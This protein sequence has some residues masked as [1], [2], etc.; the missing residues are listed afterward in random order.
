MAVKSE[1]LWLHRGWL[2][3]LYFPASHLLYCNNPDRNSLKSAFHPSSPGLTNSGTEVNQ[4]TRN[5][6]RKIITHCFV[7]LS[8]S[9]YRE[10]N[11]FFKYIC[12]TIS[13]KRFFFYCCSCSRVVKCPKCC[14]RH[15]GVCVFTPNCEE[16]CKNSGLPFDQD[17]N[18][19]CWREKSD[20][21]LQDLSTVLT[22]CNCFIVKQIIWLFLQYSLLQFKCTFN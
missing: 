7:K 18:L 3:Q 15:V 4:Q 8:Y 2:L 12:H 11:V 10:I 13:W 5:I 19:F 16:S 22:S 20:F 6:Y 17:N 9:S 14:N 1:V 21:H